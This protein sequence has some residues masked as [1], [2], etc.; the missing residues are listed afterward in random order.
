MEKG[1]PQVA[2]FFVLR[3]TVAFAKSTEGWRQYIES[4]FFEGVVL[5]K[6][7]FF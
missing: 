2:P 3:S 6:T 1:A 7:A 4:Y 5:R